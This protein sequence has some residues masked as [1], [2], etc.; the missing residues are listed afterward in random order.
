MTQLVII[1]GGPAGIAAALEGARL[2]ATVTLVERDHIGGRANW[3][4]LLPSKVWLSAADRIGARDHDARLGL[5]PAGTEIDY[6]TLTAHIHQ[7]S[8]TMAAH[9]EQA[10]DAAGVRVIKGAA[11]F[12]SAHRVHIE[13]PDGAHTLDAD[14]V[15]IATGS[16][17]FFLPQIKPDGKRIIAP[18]LMGRLTTL[19]RSMAVIGAGVT[20]AEFAYLFNRLGLSVTWI[21]DLPEILPRT[22]ADIKAPLENTLIARGVAVHKNSP[23][24]TLEAGDDGVHITTTQGEHFDVEMAFIAIG[25][26]AHVEGLNLEAAGL[27]PDKKGLAVDAFGQTAVHGIYAAGDVAGAPMTANKGVAQGIIAARHALGAPVN[28]YRPE[29]VVEAVYTSPQVAQVGLTADNAQGRELAIYRREYRANLKAHLDG[30]PDGLVK[31]LADADSGE[32]LGGAAV[33]AHAADVLAPIATAI[34]QGARLADL[35]GVFAGYPT[36]SEL[37]LDAL[38]R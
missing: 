19:P 33:G 30:A 21:T 10:L 2:G 9:D 15:I 3:H 18:R 34:A 4:S 28:G 17:P 32:I 36:L 31:V 6:T 13:Q 16:G 38:R 37:A 25:R 11:S 35:Q 7:L 5:S 22:D 8:Q 24:A 29:I 26:V 12:E 27:S 14:A 23:V 20:G 1:G